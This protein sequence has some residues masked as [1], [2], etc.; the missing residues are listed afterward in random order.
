MRISQ[1]GIAGLV[2]AIFGSS[3]FFYANSTLPSKSGFLPRSVSILIVILAFALL[4]RSLC[5]NKKDSKSKSFIHDPQRLSLSVVLTIV[6]LATVG[7]I[8]F[9]ATTTAF[10]ILLAYLTGYRNKLI[11]VISSLGFSASI[12]LMFKYLFQRR[13]PE[14]LLFNLFKGL[15]GS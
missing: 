8:G 5:Q 7:S 11:L 13:L 6:Y 14:E 1:D 12:Y 4:V 9:F 10:V 2:L 3:A 15:G